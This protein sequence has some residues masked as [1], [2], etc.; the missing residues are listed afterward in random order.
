MSTTL[1]WAFT[2]R[3]LLTDQAKEDEIRMHWLFGVVL[4][5][6]RRM[7]TVVTIADESYTLYCCQ[8]GHYSFS[9]TP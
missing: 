4:Y 9:T 5:I 3:D 6:I 7:Y 8:C 2:A 1:D